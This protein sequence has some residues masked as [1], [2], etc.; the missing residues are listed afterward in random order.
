MELLVLQTKKGQTPAGAP[1]SH[2]PPVGGTEGGSEGSS[3]GQFEV[4]NG[5]FAGYHPLFQDHH[6]LV[7]KHQHIL[8]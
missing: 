4:K 1:F 7:G 8:T 3:R 5:H 2:F 6:Q